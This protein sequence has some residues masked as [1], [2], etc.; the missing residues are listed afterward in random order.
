MGWGVRYGP[1][2][3][4]MP[5]PPPCESRGDGGWGRRACQAA[6]QLV[7]HTVLLLLWGV[8]EWCRPPSPYRP[9]L[10]E[11]VCMDQDGQDNQRRNTDAITRPKILSGR[12][13]GCEA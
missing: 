6:N 2:L 11:Q 7:E 10:V 4:R 8:G 3:P 9:P 13:G 5:R 1:T 12:L